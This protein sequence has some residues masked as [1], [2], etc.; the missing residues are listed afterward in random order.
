MD[1]SYLM[2]KIIGP[3]CLVIG[4]GLLSNRRL[5]SQIVDDFFSHPAVRLLGG[6]V[7]LAI[8]LLVV[9]FHNE[10]T[11]H[12]GLIITILGWLM[13]I[14]G[15]MVI[16]SPKIVAALAEAYRRHTTVLIVHATV[17]LALGVLLTLIGFWPHPQPAA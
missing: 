1:A 7:K 5:W 6:G 11:L 14:A 16:I 10:W 8:G 12:W 13:V 4:A 3:F 15:A 2:A 17:V 9:A